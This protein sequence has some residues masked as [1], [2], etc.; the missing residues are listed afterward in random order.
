MD[1][2]AKRQYAAPI[3]GADW[4]VSAEDLI[5]VTLSIALSQNVPHWPGATDEQLSAVAKEVIAAL[6]GRPMAQATA[7]LNFKPKT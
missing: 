3:I 7:R 4:T 5:A 1:E 6:D 2:I